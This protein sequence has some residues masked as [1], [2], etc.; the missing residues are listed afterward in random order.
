ML[1]RA[2]FAS[3]APLIVTAALLVQ[4]QQSAT[5]IAVDASH[6]GAAMSPNMF[7]IFIEDINFAADGGL[8]PERIKNRSFEFSEPL[9]GWHGL[10][11][12]RATGELD[13]RTDEALNESN[14]HYLRV[15]TYEP[16]YRVWNSGFRGIG[17][18]SGA[19]YRLSAYVRSGGPN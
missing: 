12:G 14:P 15:R 13:V 17:V 2:L 1:Q 11:L 4:G 7:G 8:Y 9:A 19:E 16:G 10:V 5:L 3:F 6:P 18:E